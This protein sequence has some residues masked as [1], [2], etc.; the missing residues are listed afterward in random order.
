[1]ADEEPL[2]PMLPP[3]GRPTAA[4]AKKKAMTTL[5]NVRICE[6]KLS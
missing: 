5:F 6:E 4:A 1:M 3:S 2:Q